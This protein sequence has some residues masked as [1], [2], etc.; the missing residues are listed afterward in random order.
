M[1]PPDLVPDEAPFEVVLGIDPGTRVL[2]WGAVLAV[3]RAPRLLACGVLTAR[4]R[5]GIALR[6]GALAEQLEE[7]L[8]SVKPSVVAVE[9]AFTALNVKSALR[10]GEARGLVL[11]AAGRR[12]VAVDEIAPA[13]AKR[14]VLGNGRATKEQVASMVP[15]LLGVSDE[16]EVPLDATDALALA[17]AHLRRREA[18]GGSSLAGSG[19]V[20]SNGRSPRSTPRA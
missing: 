9:T 13:T 7:L 3:P 12:G 15:K 1:L 20:P 16:L 6:L 19:G 8:G 10:I 17:L 18:P 2:G 11:A 4:A 14:S 5:D